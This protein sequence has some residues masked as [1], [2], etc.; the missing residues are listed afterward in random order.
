MWICLYR[1]DISNFINFVELNIGLNLIVLLLK[2]FRILQESFM[3]AS[4]LFPC[5]NFTSVMQSLIEESVSIILIPTL[6]VTIRF[7]SIESLINIMENIMRLHMTKFYECSFFHSINNK[8]SLLYI[9]IIII[10]NQNIQNK[11]K[12]IIIE[13]KVSKLWTW[14]SVFFVKYDWMYYN[15]LKNR[16]G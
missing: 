10:N 14:K 9:I 11:M 4:Y 1:R 15:N 12:F 8:H 6:K 13:I 7:V 2:Q 16:N 3:K 5:T